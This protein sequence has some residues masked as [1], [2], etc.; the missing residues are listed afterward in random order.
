MAWLSIVMSV[1]FG[2]AGGVHLWIAPEHYAH[3]PAHGLFFAGVGVVQIALALLWLRRPAPLV[4]GLSLAFSGGVWALWAL[5]HW[6]AVP[7]AAAAHAVDSAAIVTKLAEG[8]AFLLIISGDL[9]RRFTPAPHNPAVRLSRNLLL[10]VGVGGAVWALA[11]VAAPALPHLAEIPGHHDHAHEH[12]YDHAGS[13]RTVGVV[14]PIAD[15]PEE[16]Y[17]WNLPAGFP[18]PYVPPDNPMTAE[19]VLLGRFL[20]YDP[21]LSGNGT[22]ACASCH[23][24]ALAFSDG[25][26]VPHGSTGQ[27]L[28]RNSQGL[29]NVAYYSTLTWANPVLTDL[30]RQI[31]IP[32]FSEFPVEMGVTGHEA[33]VL[34]RLRSDARYQTLFAEAFPDAADPYDWAYIVQALASFNRA[35]ISAN[36]AY[37]RYVLGDIAAL[38]PS[39]IRGMDL[40]LSEALECHHCHGGFNFTGSTRQRTTTFIEAPFHNT[41]L[42]N[43]DRNGAYP[44]NNT[45]V[46]EIT[47]RPIDMGR[48]RA[49]SLRNV[50]LTAPYMHDGSVATLE[51]VIRIY[52]AGGRLI[53]TGP[54]A[55]DGRQ[56]PLKSGFVAGFR[57]TDA[58]RADLL[59]FLHALTDPTFITDPRFSD[60]FANEAR[61]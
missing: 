29:G 30:E 16:T 37:D 56:S 40:F 28:A 55:G 41:G 5:T 47:N 27:P 49:P 13:T 2:V 58:E 22:M 19:K 42:Y 39:E 33:E 35:L 6:I 43:L 26:T 7:F 45:G 10:S 20:F 23:A 21:R 3:A 9:L 44:A 53:H 14:A 48:F 34:A 12:D 31:L 1:C 17:A 46:A 61:P 51:E 54:F 11:L 60:P 38:T 36:S 4:Y 57:L 25:Q 52:E 15:S 8:G 32:L 59:A 18:L 50:A 24:Q